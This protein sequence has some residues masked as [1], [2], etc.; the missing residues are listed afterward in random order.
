MSEMS[1]DN[2]RITADSCNV[3]FKQARRLAEEVILG[4]VRSPRLISWIDRKR[5]EIKTSN[6]KDTSGIQV[7]INNSDYS[8]IFTE[9]D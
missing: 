7:D 8:F 1:L 6:G 5:G 9:T 2:I 3:D 4:M